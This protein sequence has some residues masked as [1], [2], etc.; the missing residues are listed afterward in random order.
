M[1]LVALQ[2][3]GASDPRL[4]EFAASYR[5][6]LA[7]A[8]AA[9]AWPLGDAWQSRFGQP[10]A[11]PAYRALFAEWLIHEERDAVLAQVLPALMPGCGAA[12]F[13]GLIRT[14]YAVASGHVGEL[15]DGLAYWAC[16]HLP[17]D[18]GAGEGAEADPGVVLQALRQALSGWH[19]DQGLIVQRMQQAALQPAFAPQVMRLRIGAESLAA[20]SR[21]ATRL[22]AESGN[23][24]VLHLVTSCHALRILLPYVDAPLPALRSYW[25]AYAAGAAGVPAASAAATPAPDAVPDWPEIVARAVAS[26]DEHVIKLVCS[27]R[28]EHRFYG[29]DDC[30]RAA[31]RAVSSA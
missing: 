29:W 19:P 3:L 17:L 20:L 22:Y 2:A 28:D 18:G 13:H 30:R 9:A 27:C 4:D 16:R 24:T 31:A 1:A 11:W 25:V 15:A 23:F 5:R 14:A 8:P 10:D 21:L 6:K 7:P 12:A 26:D